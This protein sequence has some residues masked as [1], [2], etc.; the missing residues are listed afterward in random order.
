MQRLSMILMTTGL[1]GA[2][3][4]PG[5]F[6]YLMRAELALK[7][8]TCRQ[9]TESLPGGRTFNMDYSTPNITELIVSSNDSIATAGEVMR[10]PPT[11]S[12]L[13]A[14]TAHIHH[15]D[16]ADRAAVHSAPR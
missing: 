8:A 16:A 13:M 3:A 1:C 7:P 9:V 12:A 2:A 14:S 10:L 11:Y 4:I 15:L 5:P 6:D